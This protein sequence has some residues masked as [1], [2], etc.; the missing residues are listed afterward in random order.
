M[1]LNGNFLKISVPRN[2]TAE[3]AKQALDR[4]TRIVSPD[5]K[6]AKPKED[7]YAFSLD[8]STNNWWGDFDLTAHPHLQVVFRYGHG[9]SE[10][11][12]AL[13]KTLVFLLGVEKENQA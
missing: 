1:T 9:H 13:G 6:E 3:D 2:W 7:G 5:Q 4:V 8:E 11:L 12:A 10:E